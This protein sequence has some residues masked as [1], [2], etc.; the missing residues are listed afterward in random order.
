MT[1]ISSLVGNN[2]YM[3]EI[4]VGRIMKKQSDQI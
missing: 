1:A 3:D 2:E 4:S